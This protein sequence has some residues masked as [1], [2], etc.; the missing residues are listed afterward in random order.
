MKE[1][2]V[3]ELGLAPTY[4]MFPSMLFTSSSQ[5]RSRALWQG[6]THNVKSTKPNS[7]MCDSPAEIQ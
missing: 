4:K 1:L 2:E 3:E 7:A 6:A 5:M